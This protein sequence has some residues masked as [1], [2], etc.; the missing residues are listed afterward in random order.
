MID[1]HEHLIYGVDDGSPDLET[2][3]AMTEEAVREGITHIVCTPHSSEEYQYPRQIIQERW[4]ELRER[5]KGKLELSLG[6]DFHMSADNILEALKVPM[7]YSVNGNGYLLIEFSN[8]V[9]GAAMFDAIYQLQSAGYKLIVT[10]PERYPAVHHRPELIREWIQRNCLIQV[11]A[12]SLYGRCGPIPEMLANEM[13]E[14][15]WIHFLATDAHRVDW[16]PPHLKK[17]YDYVANKAGEETARRLCVTNPR[18]VVDGKPLGA[19]PEA[20]GVWDE[21][22]LRLGPRKSGPAAGQVTQKA[23]GGNGFFARL[24]GR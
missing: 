6:C 16:R 24:F 20:I 23:K 3:L 2:S 13:L 8:N 22:P 9:I 14:R 11:T 1:I 7:S 18:A 21:K 10:H 5:T 17:A 15:N 4:Q 19:Q 12:N